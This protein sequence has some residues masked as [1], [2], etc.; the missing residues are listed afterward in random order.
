MNNVSHILHPMHNK[1]N[2]FCYIL[3]S[4]M[5]KKSI[6][7]FLSPEEL[8]TFTDCVTYSYMPHNHTFMNKTHHFENICNMISNIK[9]SYS[10]IEI[11]LRFLLIVLTFGYFDNFDFGYLFV[12]SMVKSLHCY[13]S[14]RNCYFLASDF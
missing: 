4:C 8:H 14:L 1:N 7:L 9:Y 11:L 5:Y 6:H 13:L 10:Y 2:I 12:V 3:S